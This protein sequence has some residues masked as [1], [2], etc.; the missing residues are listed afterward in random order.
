MAVAT[1]VSRIGGA[2]VTWFAIWKVLTTVNRAGAG[3]L[4][5]VTVI[6]ADAMHLRDVSSFGVR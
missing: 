6:S 2:R 1:E 3:I 4:S 5:Q